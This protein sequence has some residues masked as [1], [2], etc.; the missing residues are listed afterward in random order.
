MGFGWCVNED[1]L[2]SEVNTEMIATSGNG[3]VRHVVLT[4]LS[5][6]GYR[7]DLTMI[8]TLHPLKC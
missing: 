8:N 4:S 3:G 6:L 2:E 7:Q 5:L 1:M